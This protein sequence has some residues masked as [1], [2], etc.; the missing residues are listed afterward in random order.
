MVPGDQDMGEALVVPQQHIV[1]GA[2][3]LDEVDLEE[4]RLDLR[5]R[6]DHLHGG[7]LGDHA[8]DTVGLI[9]GPD[10]SGDAPA[11]RARLAD[12]EHLAAP[13]DHA[14]DARRQRHDAQMPA[15]RFDSSG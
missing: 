7:G 15:D 5:M 6:R 2:Q 10:I 8:A 4:Q 13:I 11:Q 14:V 9:V 1:A 3:L 12:I